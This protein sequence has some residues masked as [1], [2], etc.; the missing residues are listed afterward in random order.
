[1]PEKEGI[2]T[3][4][5]AHEQSPQTK[6]IAIP[7]GGGVRQLDFLP[8]EKNLG[9]QHTLAKPFECRER[10]EEVNAVLES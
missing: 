1:M 3:I 2:K 7:G 8:I 4:L 6:I 9:T 10:L 5:E